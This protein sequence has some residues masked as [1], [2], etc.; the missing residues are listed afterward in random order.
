MH[1]SEEGALLLCV[2][3]IIIFIVFL[4]KFFKM[5]SNIDQILKEIKKIT[6]KE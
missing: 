6:Q 1:I 4:V 5:S 3:T 2:I